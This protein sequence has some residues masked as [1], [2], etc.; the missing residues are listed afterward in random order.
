MIK[1]NVDSN[2]TIFLADGEK[3]VLSIVTS[4]DREQGKLKVA[5]DGMLRTDVQPYLGT[6]LQF[7]SAADIN[8]IEID[9]GKLTAVSPG[10][11]GELLDLK[12]KMAEKK[13]AISFTNKPDCLCGMEK[14]MGKK[15]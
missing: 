7:Y 15:L 13:A 11:F 1:K 6:E 8:Q 3:N 12:I 10:C 2:G 4:V 5:F 9:C 14:L